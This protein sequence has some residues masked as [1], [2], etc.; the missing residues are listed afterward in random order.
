M[1]STF[2]FMHCADLHLGGRFKGITETDPGLGKSMRESVFASFER[3]VDEAIGRDADALVISGD[4]YDGDNQL[5]STRLWM[6]EQLRL[7]GMPV[8]MC[9]GNHDHRTSW[10]SS[11]PYSDNVH[12]FGEVPETFTVDTGGGPFAVTGVSFADLHEQRNLAGM[13]SGEPDMFTVGCVHCDV[14]SASEGHPYAPCRLSDLSGRDID[15]WALGH[16]HRRQVVSEDP[17]VV[18]PGNVQG[19]SVKESGD[20]GAYLVTVTDGRVSDLEFVPTQVYTWKELEVDITGMDLDSLCGSFDAGQGDIVRL[21]FTGSGDLDRMLRTECD[22]VMRIL[23][24]RKRCVMM[25]P[26]VETT[27]AGACTGAGDGLASAIAE[28]G[29]EMSSMTPEEILDIVCGHKMARKYRKQ[30]SRMSDAE[31]RGF[32]DQAVAELISSRGTA[33]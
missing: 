12:E 2:R 23:S 16:I 8:F 30:Y 18:Y 10:D 15:Y 28:I 24:E 1:G 29:R 17:Y 33:Q 26:K 3:V 32:V 11:I 31:V 19:R 20:K 22:D 7:A 25:A 4:V 9:R 5:P 14:D 27:P 21:V 13:L 6:S